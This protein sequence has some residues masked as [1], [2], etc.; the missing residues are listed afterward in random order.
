MKITDI[1]YERLD[2]KLS[3]PYTIAYE[4]VS[5]ATN[6]ILKVETDGKICGYGS[7][8]TRMY[9]NDLSS[10]RLIYILVLNP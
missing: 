8:V 5:H 10:L 7:F 3:E 1:Q 6:F 4:T 9:G 2:L